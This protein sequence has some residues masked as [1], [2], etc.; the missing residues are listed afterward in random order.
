MA[1]QW[2]L[3]LLMPGLAVPWTNQVDLELESLRQGIARAGN[4]LAKQRLRFQ[5]GGRLMERGYAAAAEEQYRAI[6]P[7]HLA[8]SQL[9]SAL[10]LALFAQ[11]VCKQRWAC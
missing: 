3:L 8:R 7:G 5:L 11:P 2:V 1:L 4:Q 9:S 6:T 10:G